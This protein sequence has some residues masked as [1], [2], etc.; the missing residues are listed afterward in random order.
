MRK[1]P[2]L[3]V[4]RGGSKKITPSWAKSLLARIKF[5]RRKGTRKA[6]R[7]LGDEAA[8][9]CQFHNMVYNIVQE[10]NI[11]PALCIAA[12]ETKNLLPTDKYTVNGIKSAT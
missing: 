5:V 7:H 10:N 9:G 6:K 3:L 12:D 4:E 2:Q 11:P 1:A 8:V